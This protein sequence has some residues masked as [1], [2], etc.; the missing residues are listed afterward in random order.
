MGPD[1]DLNVD[2]ELVPA[3]ELGH[4]GSENGRLEFTIR[5]RALELVIP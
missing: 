2:G 3:T 1:H 4:D 5:K